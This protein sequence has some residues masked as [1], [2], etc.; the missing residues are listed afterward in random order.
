MAVPKCQWCGKE[1]G[2]DGHLAGYHCLRVRSLE[3]HPDGFSVKRVEFEHGQGIV[4]IDV[5]DIKGVSRDEVAR[6]IA[7]ALQKVMSA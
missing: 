1:L 4:D 3:F 5:K 2:K 6:M 7:E